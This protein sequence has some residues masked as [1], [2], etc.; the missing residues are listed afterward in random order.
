M[1]VGRCG[2]TALMEAL[3]A[4]P[5]VGTPARDVASEDDEL[6]HPQHAARYAEHYARLTGLTVKTQ[7]QLMHAFY[8]HNRRRAF[9]GF[10]TMPNRHD[11]FEKF[12]RSPRIQFISLIRRDIPSTVASFLLAMERGC[13][14]RTGG[15]QARQ[16]TFDPR[17]DGPA[18]AA[19]LNYVMSSIRRIEEIPGAIA[20]HYEDLCRDDF[21][22]SRLDGFF[23]RRIR[24]ANPLPPLH[25]SSYVG[26][27][28]EFLEF[29]DLLEG[30]SAWA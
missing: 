27:W 17:R 5:D 19:N 6:L 15:P 4:H 21:Q 14:R 30:D 29:L 8:H 20:L 1:T 12:T 26:N 11:N 23:A 18:A 24:I 10:K 7:G 13:W 9:A 22:D 3:R 28:H 25:G 16:W 2:S